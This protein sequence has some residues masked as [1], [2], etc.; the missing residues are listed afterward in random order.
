MFRYG[1]L[2]DLIKTSSLVISHC[3]AGILLESLR[4]DNTIC[5]AVVNDSL[6]GNHQSEIAD[7]LH[8]DK[9]IA[10]ATPKTV[11]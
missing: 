4:A 2:A 11:I 10:Q 1:V 7:A 5:C 6:M 8:K 3:G 9:Y